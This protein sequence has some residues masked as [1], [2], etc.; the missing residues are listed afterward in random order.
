MD[1]P[2]LIKWIKDAIRTE[3]LDNV[4]LLYNLVKVVVKSKHLNLLSQAGQVLDKL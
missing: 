2:E 1:E 3:E 4:N